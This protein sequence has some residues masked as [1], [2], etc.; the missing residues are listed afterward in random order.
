LKGGSRASI[1]KKVNG[2]KAFRLHKRQP[3]KHKKRRDGQAYAE[4]NRTLVVEEN[5]GGKK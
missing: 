4:E 1:K 5:P 2:Q 3:V